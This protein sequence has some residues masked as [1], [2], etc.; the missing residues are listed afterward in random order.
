[1]RTFMFKKNFND[2]KTFDGDGFVRKVDF[3]LTD[4]IGQ[5]IKISIDDVDYWGVGGDLT[6]KDANGKEI[7]SRYTPDN[8]NGEAVCYSLL[9]SHRLAQILEVI[10]V[11]YYARLMLEGKLQNPKEHD[12]YLNIAFSKPIF[13]NKSWRLIANLFQISAE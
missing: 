1:M 7:F 9:A 4:P 2:T 5:T 11:H 10:A 12:N 8:Y 3:T 13:C 6:V